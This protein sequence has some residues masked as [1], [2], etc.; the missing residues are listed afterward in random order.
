MSKFATCMWS[1][2]RTTQ[3]CRGRFCELRETIAIAFALRSRFIVFALASTRRR[4]GRDCESVEGIAIAQAIRR[5]HRGRLSRSCGILAIAFAIR[6]SFI[7]A[8]FACTRHHR[9]RICD[10]R[11]HLRSLLATHG[12]HRDRFS[13]RSRTHRDHSCEVTGKRRA[14]L[15]SVLVA[16]ADGA[17]S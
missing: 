16:E 12:I 10:L 6:S 3:C 7:V 17:K 9:N 8:A 13:A 11:N 4:H 1:L 15:S 5:S 14:W 2:S